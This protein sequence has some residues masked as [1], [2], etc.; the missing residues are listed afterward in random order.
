MNA[1]LQSHEAAF[2]SSLKCTLYID[3][4]SHDMPRY[5]STIPEV[6]PNAIC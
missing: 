6:Q 5:I 1:A 3:Y 4:Y 2:M